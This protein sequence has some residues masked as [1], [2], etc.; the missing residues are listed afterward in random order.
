[1]LLIHCSNTIVKMMKLCLLLM[2]PAL[3]FFIAVGCDAFIIVQSSSSS[4]SSS[5]LSPTLRIAATATTQLYL[6]DDDNNNNNNSN[7][8]KNDSSSFNLASLNTRLREVKDKESIIPLVVF[9]AMLPRQSLTLNVNNAKLLHLIRE[10]VLTKENPYIGMVGIARLSTG[11]YI[12][13]KKGVEVEIIVH[14]KNNNINDDDDSSSKDN[15]KNDDDDDDDDEKLLLPTDKKTNEDKGI[16]VTLKA[17]ERRFEIDQ[18]EEKVGSTRTKTYCIEQ[19]VDG[20][21]TEAKVTYL[22]SAQEEQN[23]IRGCC[24]NKNDNGKNNNGCTSNEQTFYDRATVARAILKSHEFT[25][26]TSSSSSGPN[27][28]DTTIVNSMNNNSTT[29]ATATDNISLV[30]RWIEL[31]KVHERIPGQIDTLLHQLGELPSADEPTER[32]FWIGALINPIPAMGV[33]LEIRPALLT[34]T[35]VEDRVDIALQGITQSIQHM[36]K[37]KIQRISDDEIMIN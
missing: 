15:N 5:S 35:K 8:D 36:S 21:W 10:C 33:A 4:S 14:D 27:T 1:M 2:T 17:T 3:L 32:A 12:H 31:A 25:T 23:E 16:K 26:T 6:F 28:D 30:D 18:T 13:L 34:A 22:S 24:G 37:K 29:T 19:N 7:D 11:D 9:D 20:G